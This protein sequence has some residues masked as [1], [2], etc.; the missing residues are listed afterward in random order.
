MSVIG[1]LRHLDRD[2]FASRFFCFQ[3]TDGAEQPLL[4]YVAGRNIVAEVLPWGHRKRLIAAVKQLLKVIRECR[5]CVIHTHDL[6]PDIVGYFAARVTGCAWISTVHAWHSTWSGLSLKRRCIEALRA[7]LLA[8]C[9]LVIAVSER[10]RQETIRRG[11]EPARVITVY[12]GID[13]EDLQPTEERDRLRAS[14]GF[15]PTDMVIGNIARLHPEKGQDNLLQ[16]FASVSDELPTARLLVVGDGTLGDALQRTATRLGIQAKIRFLSFQDDVASVLSALD[17]FALSS[18]AEGMPLI[19][20]KAMATGLPI[21]ASNVGGI[22]ELLV[23]EETAILVPPGDVDALAA[24]LRRVSGDE[25]A[26]RSSLGRRARLE[27]TQD[28]RCSIVT[29]TRRLETLYERLS[30]SQSPARG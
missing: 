3:E 15:G 7:R 18:L 12:T 2:R 25:S 5:P 17:V 8:R 16:A 13:R 1:W 30:A 21:V 20:Y 22:S 28:G 23:D 6:R 26:V 9:D 11:I 10:T 14:L 4:R 27:A 19:I 24:A 29:S